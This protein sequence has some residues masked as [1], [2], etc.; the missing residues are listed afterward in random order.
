MVTTFTNL[1]RIWNKFQAYFRSASPPDSVGDDAHS[2]DDA[3]Q[4]DSSESRETETTTY[5][6]TESTPPAAS[7][8]QTDEV[9]PEPLP[10]DGPSLP[11]PLPYLTYPV[12]VMTTTLPA[13]E[14]SLRPSLTETLEAIATSTSDQPSPEPTAASAAALANHTNSRTFTIRVHPWYNDVLRVIF[15]ILGALIWLT[16][17]ALWASFRRARRAWRRLQEHTRAYDELV[18]EN[19]AQVGPGAVMQPMFNPHRNRW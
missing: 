9:E 4:S 2:E 5:T 11:S 16:L 15:F 12:V 17:R 19:E 1:P 3:A 8:I 7:E 13:T 14:T 18:A 10:P 6:V